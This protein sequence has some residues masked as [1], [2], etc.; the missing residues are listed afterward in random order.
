M[1]AK[2]TSTPDQYGLVALLAMPSDIRDLG[3]VLVQDGEFIGTVVHSEH[4]VQRVRH[5]AFLNAARQCLLI[6]QVEPRVSQE[7]VYE[8]LDELCRIAGVDNEPRVYLESW[9]ASV[10]RLSAFIWKHGH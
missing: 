3:E 4:A 5:S 8:M 2:N 9:V 10:G 6:L 7:V 1:I